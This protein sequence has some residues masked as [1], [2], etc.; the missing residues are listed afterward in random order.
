[1]LL[2][3]ACMLGAAVWLL[4]G[5]GLAVSACISDGPERTGE[6]TVDAAADTKIALSAA[7]APVDAR[8]PAISLGLLLLPAGA[9]FL[10]MAGY[11]DN[12]TL[13]VSA[14]QRYYGL[15]CAY[16]TSSLCCHRSI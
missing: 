16:F 15:R 6:G 5:A 13:Y 14:L 12:F 1:M 11:S 4:R 2:G 9:L 7:E 8:Q 3:L 10:S